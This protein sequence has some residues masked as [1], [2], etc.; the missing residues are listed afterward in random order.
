MHVGVNESRRQRGPGDV[1]GFVGVALAQPHDHPVGDCQGGSDEL[2][3]GIGKH[4][5]AGDQQIGGLLAAGH[6][7]PAPAHLTSC[8]DPDSC[9]LP[10]EVSDGEWMEIGPAITVRVALKDQLRPRRR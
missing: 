4:V 6:R 10:G 1:D 7:Q 5:S 9:R 8:H 3:R 2:A